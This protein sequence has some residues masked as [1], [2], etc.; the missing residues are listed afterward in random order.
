MVTE[1]PHLQDAHAIS[2]RFRGKRLIIKHYINSSL[3]VILYFTSVVIKFTA[4]SLKDLGLLECV[5]DHSVLSKKPFVV[6]YS[7]Y[8]LM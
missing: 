7:S 1:Q 8:Y 3:L 5:N 6:N 4:S 2:E